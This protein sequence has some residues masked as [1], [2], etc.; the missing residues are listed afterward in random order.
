MTIEAKRKVWTTYDFRDRILFVDNIY[1]AELAVQR[2][3]AVP[4]SGG[5]RVLAVHLEGLSVGFRRGR[6]TLL[7]FG[8]LFKTWD[9]RDIV[10]FDVEVCP[11]IWDKVRGLLQS[12]LIRKVFHGCINDLF[13]IQQQHKI[14]VNNAYDTAV[15]DYVINWQ[16]DPSVKVEYRALNALVQTYGKGWIPLNTVCSSTDMA[17]SYRRRE[18]VWAR[19]PLTTR[20]QAFAAADVANAIQVYSRIRSLVRREQGRPMLEKIMWERMN[21][22]YEP[23]L[24]QQSQKRRARTRSRCRRANRASVL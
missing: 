1:D 10:M 23:D 14:R 21:R 16:D 20:L 7:T 15:A 11:A 17:R 6:A 13:A 12:S 22:W 4:Q 3:W 18:R 24:V 9:G 2:L 19:R 8:S 5:Q